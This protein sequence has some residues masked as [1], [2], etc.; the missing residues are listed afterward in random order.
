MTNGMGILARVWDNREGPA[1]PAT[2]GADRK[3]N[4]ICVGEIWFD[5]V[6][7]FIIADYYFCKTRANIKSGTYE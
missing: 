7:G 4:A 6:E 5:V 3:P 1:V 2:V